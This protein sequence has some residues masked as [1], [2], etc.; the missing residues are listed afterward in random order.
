AHA[1]FGERRGQLVE[2]VAMRRD[3]GDEIELSTLE[4]RDALDRLRLALLR[5]LRV[6]LDRAD[7]VLEL[8]LLVAE[9]AEA[10]AVAL[11]LGADAGLV[12]LVAHDRDLALV[13]LR[14][15]TI[16]RLHHLLELGLR[17]D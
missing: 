2:L 15:Q 8:E 9:L 4:L 3:L 5:R 16:E 11:E 12:L 1:R 14:A 10:I 13:D 17:G 6:D 7:A